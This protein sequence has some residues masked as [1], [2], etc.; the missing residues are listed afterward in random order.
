MHLFKY[1]ESKST[2]FAVCF[3]FSN[4]YSDSLHNLG[5]RPS[6]LLL[7]RWTKSEECCKFDLTIRRYYIICK[8]YF[9]YFYLSQGESLCRLIYRTPWTDVNQKLISLMHMTATDTR[10]TF[11]INAGP[12][13]VLSYEFF[14]QLIGVVITYI[15]ILF[16][17]KG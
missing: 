7:P 13:M 17:F 1:L 3:G 10:E 14:I 12:F 11:L 6:F 9:S 4:T 5:R 15:L 8:I 16:Q 2:L